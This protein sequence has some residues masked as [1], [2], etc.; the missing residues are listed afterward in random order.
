MSLGNR[1]DS[2]YHLTLLA[3]GSGVSGYSSSNSSQDKGQGGGPRTKRGCL[4]KKKG[5]KLDSRALRQ[6]KDDERRKARRSQIHSQGR[7]DIEAE[8]KENVER[9]VNLALDSQVEKKKATR[10]NK[11]E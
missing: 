8:A 10:R 5:D 7:A 6:V 11:L 9:E 2:I 4:Y 1:M 3:A